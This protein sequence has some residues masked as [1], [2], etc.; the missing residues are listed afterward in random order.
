MTWL[1]RGWLH[2]SVGL[3]LI[4][5]AVAACS[6]SDTDVVSNDVQ[7]TAPSLS[8]AS[9]TPTDGTTALLD[10][11]AEQHMIT[12][13][14]ALTDSGFD[15]AWIFIPEGRQVQLVFRNRG[16]TEYHY[17]VVGL[18]P[19]NLLW[20]NV[21]EDELEEGVTDDEHASHHS[22]E[23]VPWRATSRTGIKPTGDEVHAYVSRGGGRDVV[24]FIAPQ[25]GTYSVIDPLHPEFTGELTVY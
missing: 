7:A 2:G 17:R 6:G 24:R 13:N 5:V 23:F 14:I 19:T 21:P 11:I 1:N 25:I 16:A 10:A 22:S 15:P 18:E 8:A 20:I 3:V 4:G 9:A 12:L